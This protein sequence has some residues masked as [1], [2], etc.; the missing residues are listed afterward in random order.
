MRD[1]RELQFLRGRNS[2]ASLVKRSDQI[3]AFIM[4]SHTYNGNES[5]LDITFREK[6]HRVCML[7]K[8]S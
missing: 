4:H 5:G 6:M 3:Y 2:E 1:V 8:L 7:R